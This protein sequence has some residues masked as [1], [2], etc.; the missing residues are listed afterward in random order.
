MK[1]T[2]KILI[3]KI[4]SELKVELNKEENMKIIRNDLLNPIISQILDELK[5]YFIKFVCVIIF[6]IVALFIMILLNIKVI[7]H[8][9]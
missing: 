2:F 1:E 4:L 8:H 9:N 7:M 6:I 5:P 3:Q